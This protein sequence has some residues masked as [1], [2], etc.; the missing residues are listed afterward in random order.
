MRFEAY[1]QEVIV[2]G[3]DVVSV[4]FTK[5]ANFTYK[6]GQYMIV[7]LNAAGKALSHPLTMSSSPTEE[8]LEFTKKMSDSEFSMAL[9]GLKGADLVIFDAP[10]GIFTFNGEY[11]KV[12]FLAGGIGITPFKSIIQYCTDAKQTSNII[13]FYGCR[14][15]KDI[16]FK[17]ELIGLQ[18]HNPN[19]KLVLVANEAP[20]DWS[21][22]RGVISAEL[23]KAEA[24]DFRERM[25]Y[26]CGPP[27]M[28]IAM[29]KLISELSLP[30]NQLKLEALAGHT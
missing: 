11:P 28:V 14:T 18:K 3:A 16:T 12:A 1:V 25:F 10:Y 8:F 27:P 29:Q 19:L 30:L 15:D 23:I 21:G 20:S 9:R 13:L 5:P 7:T 6:P 4:R 22:A 24:P 2:R 17:E 26:A